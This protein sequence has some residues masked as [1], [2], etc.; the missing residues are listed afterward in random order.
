MLKVAC[1]FSEIMGAF[2]AAFFWNAH[3]LLLTLKGDKCK[4]KKKNE[5]IKKPRVNDLDIY[6]L[7]R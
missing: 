7:F 5:T 3:I 4:K 2:I 1:L 6:L